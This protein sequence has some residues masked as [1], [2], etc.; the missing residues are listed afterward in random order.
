MIDGT[1][2]PLEPET[3]TRREASGA[4]S[5]YS[6]KPVVQDAAVMPRGAEPS[7]QD[8]RH[9]ALSFLSAERRNAAPKGLER[10]QEMYPR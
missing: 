1:R 9:P 5:L 10:F 3:L 6:T 2:S 7:W 8:T 4:S